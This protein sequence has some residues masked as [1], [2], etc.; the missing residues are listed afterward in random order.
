MTEVKLVTNENDILFAL[1]PDGT[2][3]ELL[4]DVPNA[5]NYGILGVGSPARADQIEGIERGMSRTVYYDWQG[6]EV[7]MKA[8]PVPVTNADRIRGMSD[9]ELAE[10]MEDAQTWGGCPN[11]GARDCTSDCGSCWAVWLKSPVEVDE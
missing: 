1:M 9:E 7:E 4:V 10:F 6:N 2:Y 8:D 5:Q 3:R 11:H